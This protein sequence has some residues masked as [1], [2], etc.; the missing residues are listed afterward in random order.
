VAMGYIQYIPADPWARE[1]TLPM[2]AAIF[3][4]SARTLPQPI[5]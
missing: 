3:P 5:A 2:H 4:L 1:T